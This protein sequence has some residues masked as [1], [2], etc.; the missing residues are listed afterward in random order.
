MAAVPVLIGILAASAGLAATVNDARS[1]MGSRFEI[2]AVHASEERANTA[3]EAAWAEIDR[4]EAMIS[5]WRGDSETS[6]VNRNAGIRPVPVSPELFRLIRRAIKVSDLTNGAFD[7]TFAAAGNL[8]DF[9][10]SKPEIPSEEEITQALRS[11]GYARIRLDQERQ[12]VFLEDRDARIGFG[13]IGKGYAA[14][15]AVH[16]LKEVG[17]ES[18]LVSAGGDLVAFGRREDGAPWDIAIAHPRDRN[19]MLARIPLTEQ[20]VVTSGDYEQYFIHDGRRYSHIIDPRS[21]W[22]AAGLQA[23]TVV[24][25]DAELADALATALFVLGNKEGLSLVERMHGV[26]AI[27]VTADG[28]PTSSSGLEIK[29]D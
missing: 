23:V 4:I 1:K 14:N 9:R 19:R 20:A 16:V 17:I 24:C 11:V 6:E 12:T 13:A 25:P 21:G 2:T 7:I 26:D 5:S 3:I 29:T 8:W 28:V 10:A 15:R 22:P 27:F 18:G